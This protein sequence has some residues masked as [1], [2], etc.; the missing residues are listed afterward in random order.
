MDYN[1]ALLI[2]EMD[3]FDN[4]ISVLNIKKQFHKLALLNHPDKNENSIES[5]EKFIEIKNAYDYLMENLSVNSQIDDNSFFENFS[6]TMYLNLFEKFM[7]AIFNNPLRDND[8]I[9]KIINNIVLNT[10]K[11]TVN[12]FDNLDKETL[13][14]IYLVLTKYR[15]ILHL[16]E[17]ILEEIK[18]IIEVKYRNVEIYKFN[19]SIDDLLNNN[20]YKLYINDKLYLVPLWYRESYFDNLDASNN[21][22]I[23]ICEPE[24]PNNIK[25]D[26]KNNIYTHIDIYITDLDKIMN[27]TF[28]SHSIGNSL[29]EIPVSELYL[30]KVQYYILKDKGLTK[31]NPNIYDITNKADIIFKINLI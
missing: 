1:K 21:E 30:K 6:S 26:N 2:L 7:K 8:I 22:I 28:I 15:F 9:I 13:I 27:N 19:P 12:L 31:D 25:I 16:K 20:L 17:Y 5:N 29:F 3:D 24:L 10:T 23:V 11:I 18:E 4:N 14:D